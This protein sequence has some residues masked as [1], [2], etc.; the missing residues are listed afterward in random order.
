M[1]HVSVVIETVTVLHDHDHGPLAAALAPTLEAVERQTYPRDCYEVLLVL[2]ASVNEETIAELGTRYPAVRLVRDVA[3][4]YFAEKNAG[5]RAA[6]G[7]IVALLDAD[8]VPEADWLETLI[9]PLANGA[10]ISTGETRYDGGSFAART[11]SVPDFGTVL[12]DGGAATGIMLNNLAMRRELGLRHPLDARVRRNGGCYLLYHQLL[13]EKKRM[14]YT[15]RATVRHGLDVAGFGFVR[16]HFA[17]GYDA[18]G[19][20]RCDETFVLRGTRLFRRFGALA[21]PPLLV[22]R[23][24]GDWRRLAR[25]RAQI[26]ISAV[27]VPW[28]ALVM[29]VTRTIELAGGLTA[30]VSRRKA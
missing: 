23:M 3:P 24:F 25:T 18:V 28:Y 1:I 15:P 16:K 2:D 26:G 20:Y 13:A 6:R 22:R 4:N 19:V 12:E 7:E 10:D 9:A 29:A 17:R 11:F 8:C 14:V 5:L 30:A 27:Q 21:L